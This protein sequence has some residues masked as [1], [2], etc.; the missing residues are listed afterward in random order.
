MVHHRGRAHCNAD[1]L[2][3]MPSHPNDDT[4]DVFI[5]NVALATILR[6]HQDIR[7]RMN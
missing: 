6:S 2:S 5:A 3:R 4:V 7:R 1:A